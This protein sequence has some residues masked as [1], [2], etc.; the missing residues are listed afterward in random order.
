MVYYQA[1]KGSVALQKAPPAYLSCLSAILQFQQFLFLSLTNCPTDVWEQRPTT[2]SD[3]IQEP[4]KRVAK[5]NLVVLFSLDSILFPYYMCK[6]KGF[7][8]YILYIV[9]K[10]TRSV[11]QH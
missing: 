2:G 6:D 7:F 3:D 10:V 1:I 11:K 8:G 9:Y 4:G 5:R